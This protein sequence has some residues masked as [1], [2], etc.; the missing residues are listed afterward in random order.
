MSSAR[1][2]RLLRQR[3]AMMA[4]PFDP[5][6]PPTTC[7]LCEV[8][9]TKHDAYQGHVHACVQAYLQKESSDDA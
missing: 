6:Y 1:P 9:F 3:Q 5:T 7:A 4:R 2:G 8:T